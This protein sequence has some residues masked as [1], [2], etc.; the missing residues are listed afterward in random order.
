MTRNIWNTTRNLVPRS[1]TKILV[2]RSWYQDLATKKKQRAREAE[3]LYAGGH[4][5][6]QAELPA[7]QEEQ[8]VRGAAASQ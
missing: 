7:P 8:E 6:L 5:G 3:P 1:A 4:G 2:P